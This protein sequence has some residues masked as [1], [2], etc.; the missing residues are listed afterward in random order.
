MHAH[1]HTNTHTHIQIQVHMHIHI[2]A[3]TNM[4]SLHSQSP[5]EQQSLVIANSS[6]SLSTNVMSNTHQLLAVSSLALSSCDPSSYSIPGSTAV[7]L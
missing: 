2:H 5:L 7:A 3:L 6:S 1:K 4:F